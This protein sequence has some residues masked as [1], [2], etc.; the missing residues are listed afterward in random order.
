MAEEE[1]DDITLPTELDAED[2]SPYRR[3]QR[4]VSVR[5]RRLGRLRFILKWGLVALLVLPAVG[6]SG[7]S[8]AVFMLSSPRFLVTTADDVVLTGNTYVTP[9]E[10]TNALGLATA[11]KPRFGMN[12]LR[13]SLEEKKK[14]LESIP[15]V[16]TATVTRIYPNRLAVKLVERTPIAFVN[17]GGRLKLVDAEGV[18][19]DKPERASFDFPVLTGLDAANGQ[20]ERVARLALYSTFQHQIAGGIRGSGWMVSEVDLADPDDLKAMLVEG[21]DTLQV[22]FGHGDFQQRF[23]NFLTLLP[24]VRKAQG[25]IDSI[26]LRYRNQIIVN[27]E[28]SQEPTAGVSLPSAT[29]Q[30]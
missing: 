4:A 14:Q 5:R 28:S 13:I 23:Q 22:H 29:Q 20:A 8:L 3:R 16:R 6:Y 26:D 11:G 12:I 15:W 25:R 24:E 2:E 18:L 30:N 27:P 7:Y 17:M 10:V 9:E 19:L 1:L 21:R